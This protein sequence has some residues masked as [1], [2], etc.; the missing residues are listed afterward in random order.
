MRQWWPRARRVIALIKPAMPAPKIAVS[1]R[2]TPLVSSLSAFVRSQLLNEAGLGTSIGLQ[3]WLLIIL[4]CLRITKVGPEPQMI[5][6]K[7]LLV[8]ADKEDIVNRH[9]PQRHYRIASL[10]NA[11]LR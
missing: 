5:S 1:I 11:H 8:I 2:S 6:G 7:P 9:H 3:Q 4:Q 10:V